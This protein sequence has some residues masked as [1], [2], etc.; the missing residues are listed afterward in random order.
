MS[1]Q[2]ICQYR[3]PPARKMLSDALKTAEPLKGGS[4]K[5]NRG[6]FLNHP[7]LMDQ[8]AVSSLLQDQFSKNM[9][10]SVTRR[11]G[12]SLCPALETNRGPAGSQGERCK[13]VIWF[14]AKSCSE[15]QQPSKGLSCRVSPSLSISHAPWGVVIISQYMENAPL[16]IFAHR[17]KN[18]SPL[19]ALW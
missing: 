12:S 19:C 4:W 8:V 16:D 1:V 6:G 15:T 5:M 11:R 17:I 13:L 3:E 10:I 2:C 7:A 18:S 14:H 9:N